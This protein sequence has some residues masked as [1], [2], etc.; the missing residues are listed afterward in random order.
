MSM[1]LNLTKRTPPSRKG[2]HSTQSSVFVYQ[3]PTAL[4]ER[5]RPVLQDRSRVLSLY[6]AWLEAEEMPNL[7]VHLAEIE[8]ALLDGFSWG[9]S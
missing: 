5:C 7:K 1:N 6:K 8:A 9:I 4:T 3:T 2:E